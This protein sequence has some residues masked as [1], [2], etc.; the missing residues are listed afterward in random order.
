MRINKKL[1]D[2][3]GSKDYNIKTICYLSYDS[4]KSGTTDDI[5]H[6]N[7]HR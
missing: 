7:K 3:N 6:N 5:L 1:D 4:R 2:L